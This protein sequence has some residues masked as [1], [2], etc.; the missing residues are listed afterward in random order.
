MKIGSCEYSTRMK[1]GDAP[2]AIHIR[3]PNAA[4]GSLTSV[5]VTAAPTPYGRPRPRVPRGLFASVAVQHPHV[6]L[7]P[8]IGA[9]PDSLE[10]DW[11]ARLLCRLTSALN[12]TKAPIRGGGGDAGDL[13]S[14]P[15]SGHWW[16]S[17]HRRALG[18]RQCHPPDAGQTDRAGPMHRQNRNAIHSNLNGAQSGCPTVQELLLMYPGPVPQFLQRHRRSHPSSS[19]SARCVPSYGKST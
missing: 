9:E 14:S 5:H 13:T 15:R 3:S 18:S 4:G 16:A 2:I 10:L 12:S 11:P 17:R 19:D 8:P 7:R 1:S 6:P